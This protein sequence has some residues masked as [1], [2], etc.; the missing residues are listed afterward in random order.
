MLRQDLSDAD[1][2]EADKFVKRMKKLQDVLGEHQDSVVATQTLEQLL[3]L[4]SS[5]APGIRNLIKG[6][7]KAE[8][9]AR[10]QF[11]ETWARATE[12]KHRKWMKRTRSIAEA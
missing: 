12:K 5:H 7:K 1:Q 6:E 9:K 11:P 8:A 4:R 10:N 3:E 2:G